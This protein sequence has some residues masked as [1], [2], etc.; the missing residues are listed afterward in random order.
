VTGSV[1]SEKLGE[2]AGSIVEPFN[3]YILSILKHLKQNWASDRQIWIL[4]YAWVENYGI[5][6]GKVDLAGINGGCDRAGR[7]GQNKGRRAPYLQ[8]DSLTTV[9]SGVKFCSR[10]KRRVRPNA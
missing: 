4:R 5:T 10:E 9:L 6:C 3:T 2:T 8:V 1:R 7:N